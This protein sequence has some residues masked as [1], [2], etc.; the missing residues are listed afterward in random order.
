M[1]KSCN[2]V[3]KSVLPE[4][5]EYLERLCDPQEDQT[6]VWRSEEDRNARKQAA[7]EL[8]G[9]SEGEM[10]RIPGHWEAQLPAQASGPLVLTVLTGAG[11]PS[12]P[13][14]WDSPHSKARKQ[15]RQFCGISE[16]AWKLLNVRMNDVERLVGE[17]K[18]QRLSWENGKARGCH[19]GRW[20]TRLCG[21]EVF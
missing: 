2:G 3:E 6:R 8:R 18:R 7:P 17:A 13:V 11:R 10:R 9:P 16:Q 15:Q 12:F 4:L 21:S 20:L 5:M 14:S 1:E 19:R